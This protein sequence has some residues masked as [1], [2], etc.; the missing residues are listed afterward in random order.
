MDQKRALDDIRQ[1]LRAGNVLSRS[2][3]ILSRGML[4][5]EAGGSTGDIIT[6]DFAN[7]P[8]ASH[9]DLDDD[10]Q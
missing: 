4:R 3:R 6:Q 10:D 2:F 5:D 7:H 1:K 8:D 9:F